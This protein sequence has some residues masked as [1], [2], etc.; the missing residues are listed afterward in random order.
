MDNV[1]KNL[2]IGFIVDF[3]VV[4]IAII[5]IIKKR[6]DIKYVLVIL[7]CLLVFLLYPLESTIPFYKD[8]MKKE[9]ISFEGEFVTDDTSIHNLP[10]GCDKSYFD[11]D[12][13]GKKDN[14]FMDSSLHGSKYVC[15]KGQRYRVT[16]Y[17]H[18]HTI[19]S[20]EKIE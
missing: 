10:F 9:K 7:L 13:D 11:T 3:I 4:V 17:K 12:G 15:E 20:L 2:L 14:Y 16:I 18:S 6:H 5:Y 8:L 19:Y 1:I